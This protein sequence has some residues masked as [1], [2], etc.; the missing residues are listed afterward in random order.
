L[1][2]EAKR[3]LNYN[4]NMTTYMIPHEIYRTTNTNALQLQF[5]TK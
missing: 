2:E 3:F 4:V 5:Q 1:F